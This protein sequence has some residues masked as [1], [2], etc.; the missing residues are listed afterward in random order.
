M[1]AALQDTL[2]KAIWRGDIHA[3]QEVLDSGADA[4]AAGSTGSAPLTQAAQMWNLA[5]ARL[6]MQKG[7][8]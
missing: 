6:L 3:V 7:Q 5:I 2:V 4:N 8:M 1:S